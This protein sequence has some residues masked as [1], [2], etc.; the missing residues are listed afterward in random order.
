MNSEPE[1][2][3]TEPSEER[4]VLR[5]IVKYI[6]I[7]LGFVTLLG[8]EYATYRAGIKRGYA[9]GVASGEVTAS[10]NRR[11]VENLRHFMQVP[12]ADDAALLNVVA[13]KEESLAWIKDAALRREAEWV[14]AQALITRGK[15]ASAEAMMREL[16]KA[17][18]TP[19]DLWVHRAL[20]AA[21][22]LA[23]EKQYEQTAFYYDYADSYYATK[24]DAAMRV[25]LL[26]ERLALLQNVVT[27]PKR[28]QQELSAYAEKAALLGDAAKELL[29][30][31][32]ANKGQIYREQ[33]TVIDLEQANRCFKKALEVVD[34]ENVP[35]LASAAVCVGSLLLEQHE[36]ERAESMLRDGLSR[37]TDSRASA[38]YM[39]LALRDLARIEQEKGNLD[40]ALA[41][42]YRAEGVAMTYEPEKSTFWNCLFT[43]RGWVNLIRESYGVALS[44]FEK[45]LAHTGDNTALRVQPLEG[46]ARCCVALEDADKAVNYFTE[47]IELRKLHFASDPEARG[48]VHFYLAGVYDV[49]GEP[50]QAAKHYTEAVQLIASAPNHQADM[51][52]DA[53]MAQAYTL[54]QLRRWTEA[55]LVWKSLTELVKDDALRTN[56]IKVQLD[57][58]VLH[59]ADLSAESTDNAE[60]EEEEE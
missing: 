59:G 54:T 44:D 40:A 52:V 5:P 55:A 1:T 13:T 38:P 32:W 35:E 15:A 24:N 29:A 21:R 50:E 41:C 26:N 11:A 20:L 48:R 28:L 6:A 9:E 60:A 14:L 34:I 4:L 3:Q 39:L 57:V 8:I 49:K 43:Q 12:S 58:C 56:Q 45:A 42:L 37:L 19:T 17:T 2:P 7:G 46:A 36:R 23:A 33:G 47:C 25:T 53:M 16:I 30:G 51:L 22:A 31:I 10:V 18:G 27:E